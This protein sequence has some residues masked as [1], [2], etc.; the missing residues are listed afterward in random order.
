MKNCSHT[1]I[2][3][4]ANII[5]KPFKQLPNLMKY[6]IIYYI[7]VHCPISIIYEKFDSCDFTKNI[8]MRFFIQTNL[9]VWMHKSFLKK[10]YHLKDNKNYESRFVSK[11]HF[12]CFS[13]HQ[14]KWNENICPQ[15]NT[16][17]TR[18]TNTFSY[19]KC[20]IIVCFHLEIG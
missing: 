17:C 7:Y 8:W 20:T 2:L 13:K 14:M 12:Q 10:H 18:K 16:K 6:S 5:Q 1:G 3:Q 15:N 11:I 19:L 9:N 4:S